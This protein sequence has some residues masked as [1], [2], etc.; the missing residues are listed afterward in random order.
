M[1][2]VIRYSFILLVVMMSSFSSIVA[3]NK[4]FDSL[5][6]YD[7]K[8]IAVNGTLICDLNGFN[9]GTIDYGIYKGRGFYFAVRHN[10]A[11]LGENIMIFES[12]THSTFTADAGWKG[13]QYDLIQL[14]KYEEQYK[15]KFWEAGDFIYFTL[16]SQLNGEEVEMLY[17]LLPQ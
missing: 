12:I 14:G 5:K 9:H 17:I 3:Q 15:S 8:G 6:K 10:N 2:K 1:E 13:N 4:S 11:K 7:I 16:A